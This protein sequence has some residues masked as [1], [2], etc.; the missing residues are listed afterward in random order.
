MEVGTEFRVRIGAWETLSRWERSE[1]GKDLR[2]LGLS[3]GEIMELIPVK[4]S[5][6]ATWCREVTL[7]DEQYLAIKARTYGSRVGIPVDTNRKR[8]A[9]IERIREAARAQVPQLAK[10]PSWVAGTV[11]YWAAGAKTRNHLKL[12]N[13]DPHALRLFVR[14]T[15]TYLDPDADFSLQLHLHE[16]NDEASARSYWRGETG[17]PNAN[18]YKTFIKPK[19]TGHRKNHL[20]HGVHDQGAKV[21][22]CM[23]NDDGLDRG[24]DRTT[25]PP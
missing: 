6:L 24:S 14:W 22:R 18:F 11:L 9:E 17:L 13:A 1:L 2:R 16:G 7:S 4:K 12:A 21:R 20:E 19:G 10:D 25:R 8:R 3:Y 5:T 15:R 23:A